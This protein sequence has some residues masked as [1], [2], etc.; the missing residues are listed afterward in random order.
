MI[1]TSTFVQPVAATAER[2]R[3]ILAE[4]GGSGAQQA[5]LF[6]FDTLVGEKS[7]VTGITVGQVNG[8]TIQ[9]VRVSPVG[10]AVVECLTAHHALNYP[11][12][13]VVIAGVQQVTGAVQRVGDVLKKA[14]AGAAV[15]L[16][17]A[18]DKVYDAALRGL[19][20]DYGSAKQDSH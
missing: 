10:M 15:L 11:G 7:L 2:I 16:V 19:H 6:V 20:V 8:Q 14:P 9:D 1:T 12:K 5:Q 4:A 3:Q 18:D 13:P 17:C